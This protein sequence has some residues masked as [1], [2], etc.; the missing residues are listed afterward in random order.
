MDGVE[1]EDGDCRK[2]QGQHY[3]RKRAR[4]GFAIVVGNDLAAAEWREISIR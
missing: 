4:A 3:N 2:V 1:K